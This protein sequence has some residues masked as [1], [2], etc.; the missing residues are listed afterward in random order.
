M[1]GS[2]DPAAVTWLV[3]VYRLPAKPAACFPPAL[4]RGYFDGEWFDLA[5]LRPEGFQRV[6][7]R[8]V[9]LR[10]VD[11]GERGLPKAGENST[12]TRMCAMRRT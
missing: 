11:V 7:D 4:T 6:P 9:K 8:R 12:R 1:P 5:F 3:L 2:A 10:F